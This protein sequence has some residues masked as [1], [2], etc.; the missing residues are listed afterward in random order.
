M[1]LGHPNTDVALVYSS[2]KEPLQKL[3]IA[4]S[5]NRVSEPKIWA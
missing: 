5:R 1:F 3:A 2:R 4:N